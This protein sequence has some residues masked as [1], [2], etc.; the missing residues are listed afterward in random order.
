[1]IILSFVFMYLMR[2]CL[3]ADL[4]MNTTTIIDD[5]NRHDVLESKL[6]Q[7][8][9]R[10]QEIELYLYHRH[11]KAA[12]QLRVLPSSCHAPP[13]LPSLFSTTQPSPPVT[14]GATSTPSS[15]LTGSVVE[16]V[17]LEEAASTL[18]DDMTGLRGH[19][20]LDDFLRFC[21]SINGNV[22]SLPSKN[23]FQSSTSIG[24]MDRYE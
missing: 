7:L 18:N 2:L 3:V 14:G 10:C 17:P 21:D 9:L 13:P 24:V 12:Q 5:D 1:M 6:R 8:E 16:E 20:R 23:K 19:R 11:H 22:S 15:L 4:L